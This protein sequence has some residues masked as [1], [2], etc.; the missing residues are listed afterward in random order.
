MFRDHFLPDFLMPWAPV[1]RGPLP[2]LAASS[3]LAFSSVV[4]LLA[5]P[6]HAQFGIRIISHACFLLV[7]ESLIV[8]VELA[9][10]LLCGLEGLGLAAWFMSH[11][12]VSI[13][14]VRR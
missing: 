12:H 2:A 3:F 6:S 14:A 7:Q 10:V 5:S 13:V 11:Q 4:E 8:L 1:L 9:L